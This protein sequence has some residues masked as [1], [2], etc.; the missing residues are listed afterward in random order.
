MWATVTTGTVDTIGAAGHVLVMPDPRSL[1]ADQAAAE[2]ALHERVGY[3]RCEVEAAR[4]RVTELERTKAD[5]LSRQDELSRQIEV[6]QGEVDE[7]RRELEERLGAWCSLDDVDQRLGVDV[8]KRIDGVRSSVSYRLT[9][10]F[11]M[12]V[13][14]V[15]RL[16]TL[17]WLRGPRQ[18]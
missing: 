8:I 12:V 15:R 4:A 6:V 18:P 7:R 14:K 13:N 5:L 3:V 16:V 17:Q 9:A 10:G 1:P 11:L 2:R